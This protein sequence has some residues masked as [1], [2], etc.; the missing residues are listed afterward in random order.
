M[1][2]YPSPDWVADV[3]ECRHCGATTQRFRLPGDES[4]EWGGVVRC[5][6]CNGESTERIAEAQ[7]VTPMPVLER[8]RREAPILRPGRTVTP[9]CGTPV[10]PTY[11]ELINTM[12]RT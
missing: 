5:I 8:S 1:M 9:D 2:M 3:Y 10:A 12:E 4:E 7:P 6:A 11:A